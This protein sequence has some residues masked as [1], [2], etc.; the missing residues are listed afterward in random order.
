MWDREREKSNRF[1]VSNGTFYHHHITFSKRKLF[2]FLNCIPSSQPRTY[3]I[4]LNYYWILFKRNDSKS[5]VCLHI[6]YTDTAE[7]SLGRRDKAILHTKFIIIHKQAFNSHINRIGSNFIFTYLFSVKAN[8]NRAACHWQQWPNRFDMWTF[9]TFKPNHKMILITKFLFL[10]KF[11]SAVIWQAS[12]LRILCLKCVCGSSWQFVLLILWIFCVL[13]SIYRIRFTLAVELII[14]IAYALCAM[15]R[16]T[17][18]AY[19]GSFRQFGETSY[20]HSQKRQHIVNV[21]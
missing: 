10:V 17:L 4:R 18:N 16:R 11:A 8:V 15:L 5:N 9:P 2:L 3:F 1:H 19:I 14:V 13:F 21:F 20:N 12:M 6:N 7:L